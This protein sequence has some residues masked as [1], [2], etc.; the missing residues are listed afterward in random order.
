MTSPRC[1]GD[2]R[3][4][5]NVVM[6]GESEA[7]R[8]AAWSLVP[9]EIAQ[10]YRPGLLS[11]RGA[12]RRQLVENGYYLPCSRCRRLA[13]EIGRDG[14]ADPG[15]SDPPS[16]A[17][18]AAAQAR[19]EDAQRPA[20]SANVTDTGLRTCA[21]VAATPVVATTLPPG[22]SHTALILQAAPKEARKRPQE[23]E[24]RTR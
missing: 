7:A 17:A 10:Q 3:L 5:F 8:R 20:T 23:T 4:R 1:R 13:Y 22:E 12:D 19:N 21:S 16:D 2:V 11:M 24:R 18:V 6:V 9:G 15:C 14:C